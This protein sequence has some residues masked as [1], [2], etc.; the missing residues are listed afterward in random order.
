[1]KKFVVLSSAF[2]A[3][4]VVTLSF[5]F[6]PVRPAGL[7]QD[8]DFAKMAYMS[9]CA[10]ISAGNLASQKAHDPK[11]A[12]LGKMMVTDHTDANAKLMAIVHNAPTTDSL[13]AEHQ[14]LK[15]SLMNATGAAF[16][17]MYV[18]S[19]VRDHEKAIALFQQEATS[20]GQAELKSYAQ[21][22][23]PKLKMHLDHVMRLSGGK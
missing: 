7:Q 22:M 1:M 14:S 9:S 20:G 17:A 21:K 23:L 19:Q 8:A 3:M 4:A 12:A 18:Q 13:D 6:R 11:V 5:S 16:D 2:V 15:D 10:E